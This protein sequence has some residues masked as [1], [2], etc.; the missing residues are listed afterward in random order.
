[1]HTVSFRGK[2]WKYPGKGG[3][4]FV[5]LPVAKSPP[6]THGWGRTPVVATVDGYR[7]K[8]SV[9]KSKDGGSVL[10]VPKV[11]RGDKQGGASV[12]VHLEFSL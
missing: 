8:T 1:M 9:W 12:K 5:T 7:W 6:A 4:H 3:W 11:A 2:L 10:A